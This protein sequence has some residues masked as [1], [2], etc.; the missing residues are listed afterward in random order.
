MPAVSQR[1]KGYPS[2][3]LPCLKPKENA[4][5]NTNKVMLGFTMAHDQPRAAPLYVLMRSDLASLNICL[6]NCMCSLIMSFNDSDNCLF[7]SLNAKYS[8]SSSGFSILVFLQQL[9]SGE[10]HT[11]SCHK[12]LLNAAVRL[13][14][15]SHMNKQFLPEH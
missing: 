9:L 5:Q 3:G 1:K 14:L 6:L 10:V 2:I 13:Y 12:L 15:S 4:N 8:S 7:P 11:D